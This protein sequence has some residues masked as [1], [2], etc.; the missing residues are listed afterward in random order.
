MNLRTNKKVYYIFIGKYLFIADNSQV[1]CL[2]YRGLKCKCMGRYTLLRSINNDEP[3]KVDKIIIF[4]TIERVVFSHLPHLFSQRLRK[5]F[6]HK[7]TKMIRRLNKD[8][9]I[10]YYGDSFIV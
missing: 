5:E 8:E 3:T 2:Y 1:A 10:E 7:L 4:Q 9:K 6:S